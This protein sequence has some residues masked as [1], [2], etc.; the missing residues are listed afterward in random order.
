[1][2]REH[3]WLVFTIAIDALRSMIS[4]SGPA[5]FEQELVNRVVYCRNRSILVELEYTFG[6]HHIL[7]RQEREGTRTLNNL[8]S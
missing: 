7:K 8:L 1:M 6:W 5:Y 2:T 4:E 3:D